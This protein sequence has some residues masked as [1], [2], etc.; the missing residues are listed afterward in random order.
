ME[1]KASLHLTPCLNQV[2]RRSVEKTCPKLLGKTCPKISKSQQNFRHRSPRWRAEHT[3]GTFCRKLWGSGRGLP[4]CGWSACR[5]PP[6]PAQGAPSPS[7]GG[8]SHTPTIAPTPPQ[9]TWPQP[10]G[11]LAGTGAG[12]APHIEPLKM[13]ARELSTKCRESTRTVVIF[14]S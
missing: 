4:C 5:T 9:P 1:L 12:A 10:P 2:H 11:Q 6:Y 7:T 14:A 3:P 13:V 8:G